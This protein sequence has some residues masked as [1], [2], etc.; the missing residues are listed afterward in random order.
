[1]IKSVS[2][3]VLTQFFNFNELKILR[4]PGYFFKL[5]QQY[6]FY[7][8]KR[9]DTI[10]NYSKICNQISYICFKEGSKGLRKHI[11]T[12][13]RTFSLSVSLRTQ[14]FIT[15]FLNYQSFAI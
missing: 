2:F 11:V 14:I 13:F 1:M 15:L 5:N 3:I 6:I 7:S 8:E 9:S 10:T 12:A 4:Q